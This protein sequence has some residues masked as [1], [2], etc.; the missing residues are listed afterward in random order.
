M[1]SQLGLA[2][3]ARGFD[4]A[5][6]FSFHPVQLAAYLDVVWEARRRFPRT[7]LPNR[8]PDPTPIDVGIGGQ[9]Q[10]GPVTGAAASLLTLVDGSIPSLNQPAGSSST[11][12]ITSADFRAAVEDVLQGSVI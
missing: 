5:D 8:L 2:L 7:P 12:N 10:G 4:R 3:E 9:Q 1:F 6:V 11:N